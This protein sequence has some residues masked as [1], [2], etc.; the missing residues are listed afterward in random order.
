MSIGKTQ[1]KV[2]TSKGFTYTLAVHLLIAC[3][4]LS[5]IPALAQDGIGAGSEPR[6]FMFN[7]PSQPLSSALHSFADTTD[8]QVSIPSEIA[9]DMS[10]PGVTGSLT[11]EQGLKSLLVGTGLTYRFVGP[12]IVTLKRDS[13][14]AVVP[15]L[16]GAGAAGA[17][18]ASGNGATDTAPSNAQKPVKV[19]EILVK[20]IRERESDPKSYVAEEANTAMRTDTPIR[21][22]PQSI[23]VVTRKV[24]EEQKAI[25]LDDALQNISGISTFSQSA[26][27]NDAWFIRGFAIG[28]NNMFR[29][30]LF[31]LF[32]AQ[33][34]S[35]TYNVQRLEVLKGPASVLYGLGDPGG[36]IN[37]VTRKPLPDAAY[38]ANV[39]LGNYN[40]YRSELDATGPLNASKTL[41]YRLTVVGQKAL[42]FVDFANRDAVGVTPSITWIMGSRTT[43]TVDGE[44]F[45]RWTQRIPGLP[46][47]GTVLPNINGDIPRNRFTGM[48]NFGRNDRTV[49]RVGYDLSHQFNNNWS[50]RNMYRYSILQSDQIN[51]GILALEPD[52]RTVS[53][54]WGS[55][56]G[57]TSISRQHLHSMVTNIVGR[58]RLLQ[59][60]HT[61]LT[62]VELREV[63]QNPIQITTRTGP[64]LN[65]DL[66][67][68]DYGINPFSAPISAVRLF[69]TEQKLVGVYLQDQIALLPNL[70]L[71]GGVR[72]DYVHQFQRAGTVAANPPEQTSDD[73]GVSPR[74]GLVYQPIEPV[75]LYTSW[76][77]GF[78]PNSPGSFNPTGEL[79]KPERSTQYE[80]GIRTFFFQNR[81][82]LGLAWY[83]LTRENLVTPDP[84]PARAAQGFAVQ[85]GEQRSQGIELDVTASLADG[86]NVIASYAYTDAEVTKD[87]D[88]TL[89]N[90]RLGMIPYNKATLWSTYHFQ[91]GSLKGFGLGGGVI[92]YT[93]RNVWIFDPQVNVP[94]Y[95]IV[96]AA[97][98][99]NRDLEPNNWLKAKQINVAVNFRNLLDQRYVGYAD[100]SLTGYFYGDPRTVLA[101]V[102]LRF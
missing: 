13:S 51:G 92:G 32:S 7:I 68:P 1:L 86:W 70:K 55:G 15:G 91:E 83:H 6:Q 48:G 23:Q 37:I 21:D 98:Y 97:L 102:G 62:G 22:S 40:L 38:S 66:Y 4:S 3:Q 50:I 77:R 72:F 81:L 12:K 73:T 19:P 47:E 57:E 2:F 84:D 94:G 65:L 74:L 14:G 69:E 16:V 10:S 67:N 42:S 60:D 75:S 39:T 100:N 79:F 54:F 31:D 8:W 36:I 90:R 71:V 27:V 87:N 26:D 49:Y 33:L 20:D 59:M 28:N 82:S 17:A 99:Y 101:T 85:T 30:G 58:F 61:L 35:D 64:S 46:S 88:P 56:P 44:Y 25:R 29:N 52:Q 34:A 93:G 63:R 18:A 5:M 78:L 89:V 43:L 95:V 53:R 11:P 45:K 41:L 96:N 24:I 76:T 80:V 9:A